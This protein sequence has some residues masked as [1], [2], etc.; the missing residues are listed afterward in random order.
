M[1]TQRIYRILFLL[2]IAAGTIRLSAQQTDIGAWL[3][4][5]KLE[6][7]T[8]TDEGDEITLDFD[9]TLGF[10]LS[11]NHFW[12]ERFSTE[13]ALQ[14]YSADMILS[15]DS[16]DGDFRA[17]AGEI[18]LSSLTAIAQLHFMRASRVS[19][20]VGAGLARVWGKFDPI[21]DPTDPEGNVVIDLESETTWTAAIGA[22]VRI[23]DHIFLTG[24]MKYIPWEALAEG[25]PEE[26][27]VDVNPL[28]FAAGVKVRF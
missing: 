27:A 19:P 11:V 7:T 22:N 12:T 9:E 21:D 2:F 13:L 1:T 20:Y 10:G 28:T 24:E 17:D 14:D 23:N 16:P 25:D 26:D 5:P 18:D 6:Q 8:A 3:V 15:V 4:Q